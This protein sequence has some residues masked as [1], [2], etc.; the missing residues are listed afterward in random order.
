MHEEGNYIPGRESPGHSDID[1]RN[2]NKKENAL[3]MGPNDKPPQDSL[4]EASTSHTGARLISDVD[5]TKNAENGRGGHEDHAE[6]G[7]ETILP[8]TCPT[9]AYTESEVVTNGVKRSELAV[10]N[11]ALHPGQ[12]ASDA[13]PVQDATRSNSVSNTDGVSEWSH[14]QLAPHMEPDKIPDTEED[15]WQDMPAFATHDIYDDYGRL[16][17]RAVPDAEDENA[18]YTN[19]GGAAKGYTRVQIDEDA[20]SATSMDENTAYLFKEKPAEEQDELDEQR[21][22]LTQMQA[23]KDLLSDEQKMAYVG[24]VR[25]AIAELTKEIKALEGV[26]GAR[27]DVGVAVDA[28]KMWSQKMMVRLYGHIELNAGGLYT[29]TKQV[30]TY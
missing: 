22:P 13:T 7:H 16:L 2:V 20:Q 9:T 1:R 11:I 3:A 8:S 24:L 12:I 5:Q 18:P 15:Q 14:Q 17:A 19:L 26:R 25:L 4:R 28:M 6:A 10:I 30:F 21:D 23:T 29:S 27:K